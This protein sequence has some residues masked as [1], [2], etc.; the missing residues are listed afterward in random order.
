M[1]GMDL[2][3]SVTGVEEHLRGK[4]RLSSAAGQRTT[5]ELHRVD[6]AF[7]RIRQIA[8]HP[9]LWCALL[10]LLCALA[11]RPALEMGLD[12]DFS[13]IRTAKAL[14]DTGHVVYNGWATAMLGW[15]LYLGALFIKLFG[16]SFTVARA[17]IVL[18][19]MATA[20]LLQR[21][22]V[23]V[24]L[25]EWNATWATLTLSLSPLMLP[26]TVSFMTDVPGLFVI[27]VCFYGCLRAVQAQSDQATVRWLI[28]A[29]LSNAVG[30]TVRQIAWLGVLVMVPCTAWVIRRRRGALLAGTALCALSAVFIGACMYWF[31]RQ[32]YS[33]SEPLFAGIHFRSHKYQAILLFLLPVL[34]AFVARYP[35]REKW[36]RIQAAAVVL[37]IGV[38]AVL[39]VALWPREFHIG[40]QFLMAPFADGEVTAKGFELGGFSGERPD[41]LSMPIRLALSILTYSAFL[42]FLL[43]LANAS[44]FAKLPNAELPKGGL[45]EEI[46]NQTL[47]TVL[48]PFTAAYLMLMVTRAAVFERYFLPLLFVLLVFLLRFYQTRIA[49]RLPALTC[50]FVMVFGVYGVMALHDVLAASRAALEAADELRTAGIPRTEIRAGFQ[51]DAWTQIEQTG[52]LLPKQPWHTP[53]ECVSWWDKYTPAIHG[54]YQLSYSPSC[55]PESE[56]SPVEY[57]TWLAPHQQ[58]IY[59]LRLP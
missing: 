48:G 24:G 9:A 51:Y 3:A 57:R 34:I 46:S 49:T 11:S 16:F 15:Q 32:P 40:S 2:R 13:Y 7:S 19:G 37:A 17:P 4:R 42:A 58:K 21:L 23:R 59:I 27:L 20:A 14:A 44:R 26:L 25:T 8:M 39:W 43:S 52:Y 1:P 53:P 41:V 38:V 54:R 36:A 56:F 28:F 30:G 50:V 31:K 5:R 6:F 12:D 45:G 10:V 33:V 18:V 29:A 35:I 22:F 47:L 55:F